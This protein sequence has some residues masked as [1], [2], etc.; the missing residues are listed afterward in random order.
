MYTRR[1]NNAETKNTLS[2][3]HL[4]LIIFIPDNNPGHRSRA[5]PIRV[6]KC[7][8]IFVL[9][10]FTTW[11]NFLPRN[12]LQWATKPTLKNEKKIPPSTGV[13]QAQVP[14]IGMGHTQPQE[15]K[16]LAENLIESRCRLL[17]ATLA[18][19]P[20]VGITSNY[21]LSLCKINKSADH[22]HHRISTGSSIK[23]ASPQS[24][25]DLLGG[26]V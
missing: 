22:H 5:L 4:V 17:L 23:C 14:L 24:D 6:P 12:Q 20:L 16:R 9:A 26:V 11:I 7:L 18:H 15:V 3:P 10:H 13:G 19:H 8:F 21:F 2:S 1:M 25:R